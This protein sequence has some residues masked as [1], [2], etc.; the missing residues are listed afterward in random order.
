MSHK[1]LRA[2]NWCHSWYKIE[3]IYTTYISNKSEGRATR[4]ETNCKT[5]L[6]YSHTIKQTV[7]DTDALAD[8]AAI[9]R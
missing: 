1:T 6:V 7:T 2:F 8:A 3:N 9:N 5:P 4:C